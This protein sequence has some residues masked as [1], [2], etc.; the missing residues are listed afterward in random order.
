MRYSNFF[1][2]YIPNLFNGLKKCPFCLNEVKFENYTCPHPDCKN[3]KNPVPPMYIKDYRRYPPVIASA[4]GFRGHGKTVYFSSLFYILQQGVLAESWRGFYHTPLST[5]GLRI[6]F[7]KADELSKGK[8]PE[9]TPK[10]AFPEPVLVRVSRVPLQEDCTFLFYD[11]NGESFENPD[12]FDKYA[13]FLRHARTVLFLISVSGL[14]NPQVEMKALL[15]KYILGMTNNLKAETRDQ[16]LVVV[17]TQADKIKFSNEWHDLKTYLTEGALT[18][19]K[20]PKGYMGSLDW[21]STRLHEFTEN[22]LRAASFLNAAKGNFKSIALCMVSAL[23]TEPS[24]GQLSI[25]VVPRRI[26]DPLLWMMKKSS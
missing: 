2:R 7:E 14:H 6:I 22:E 8:L 12:E 25:E 17:Y 19:L 23:G 11:V 26:I 21:V 18:S 24:N 3:L 15:D 9:S 13:P 5:E 20:D 4:V 10:N 16:H 1:Q